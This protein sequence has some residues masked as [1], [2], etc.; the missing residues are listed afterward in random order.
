[1]KIMVLTILESNESIRA[2][3]E[4]GADGYCFKDVGSAELLNA[5]STVLSGE[6]Y[7]SRAEL[8]HPDEKRTEDRTNCDCIMQWA[9]FN[10]PDFS[11]GRLINCS[12]K[13]CLFETN[14]AVVS[15]STILI[16]LEHCVRGVQEKLPDCLRSSA[17]AEVKW[18][19][20]RDKD[21]LVG[22]RYHFPV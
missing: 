5:I 17:V 2:A 22:A 6:R 20:K 12:R 15:G 8:D 7:V 1:M 10:K 19:R 16:R 3:M 21:Y 4:A 9:Y 11:A 13:G 18:C 14:K